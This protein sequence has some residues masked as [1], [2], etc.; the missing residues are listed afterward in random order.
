MMTNLLKLLVCFLALLVRSRARLE[1]GTLV[2]RHQLNVLRRAAPMRP[3]LTSIDRLIFVWFYRLFPSVAKYMAKRRRP[4][5][6][7]WKTFLQ[8]RATGIA[9][10]DFLSSRRSAFGSSALS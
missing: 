6:Q 2:L 4:P 1:A 8:N 3:R 5:S 9:G 7:S 10:I